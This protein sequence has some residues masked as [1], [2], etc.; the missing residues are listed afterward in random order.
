MRRRE[1]D[2]VNE[3]N[4]AGNIQTRGIRAA[5]SLGQ[6]DRHRTDERDDH[7]PSPDCRGK[8]F[9]LL[10]NKQMRCAVVIATSRQ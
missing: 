6:V 4:C 10:G 1:A 2:A 7:D 5:L 8:H 3:L 9:T